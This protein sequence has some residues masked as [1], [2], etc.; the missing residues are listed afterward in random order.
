[1]LYECIVS[2]A[3][4][5]ETFSHLLQIDAET[6]MQRIQFFINFR[7]FSHLAVP[8]GHDTLPFCKAFRDFD[9]KPIE[10]NEQ[11]DVYEFGTMLFDKLENSHS[12]VRSL[13]KENFGGKLVYQV[14]SQESETFG[15][16]LSELTEPFFMLTAE[17]KN[18]N[19]LQ[20]SME[21]YVAGEPLS[22]DNK[23]DHNGEKV[24]ALRRC[25]IRELPPTLIVHLKRFEYDLT[26]YTKCKV[27]DYFSFPMKLNMLPYTEEGTRKQL[28]SRTLD[29]AR[30]G[31][32]KRTVKIR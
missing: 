28:S 10:V 29:E 4:L 14:I 12:E 24:E 31:I 5:H 18:K 20:D 27:N 11:K 26:T 16:Q 3:F 9:G 6:A 1:M 17:V 8:K 32:K 25:A 30:T 15:E 7:P 21:L 19:S 22:G 2:A 23:Y 13:L